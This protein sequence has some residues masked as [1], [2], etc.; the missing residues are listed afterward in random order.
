MNFSAIMTTITST[1]T[2]VLDI[3]IVWLAF[4]YILKNIKNN[5]KMVL[6]LKGVIIVLIVKFLSDLLNLYTV[7]II[8]EYIL[9]WGPLAIIV[10]FQPE[11]RSVLESLGR[12]KL[13]GR[14]KILTLD[15]RENI[16]HEIMKAMDYFHKNKIGALIVIE[17]EISLQQYI[18]G[19]QKIYA[20]V[21]ESL[22]ETIFF[23]NTALHDGGIII[24][25]D[26]ITC[27]G[28]VFKTSMNPEISKRLGTRH[29]AALGI[30]E[31]SDAIALI[32]SEE[33]GRLSIAIDG[34]LNYNLSM[35][36]FR[37]MLIDA[38]SPKAEVFFEAD[39]S[40]NDEE[41]DNNA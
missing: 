24:Q 13:L 2:R 11:I 41:G 15:E 27:A 5:I 31:E 39:S 4:Y 38:L 33:T 12:T 23:P 20:D 34:K 37:M 32:A 9:E 40:D 30:A 3:C 19:A 36:E 35:E 25:G 6:I 22:L 14:H 26:K 17:R 8:L 1:F 18:N 16:V 28:A 10:I 21:N 7:G 29:R